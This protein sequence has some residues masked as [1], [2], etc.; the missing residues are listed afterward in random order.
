MADEI[1]LI[2]P[3]HQDPEERVYLVEMADNDHMVEC[4]RCDY[5]YRNLVKY[6]VVEVMD[7]TTGKIRTINA[8]T[9]EPA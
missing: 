6:P 9:G 2:C 1:R 4:L 5:T 8:L 7:F 3:N